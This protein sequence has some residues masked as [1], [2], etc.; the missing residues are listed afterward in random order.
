MFYKTAAAPRRWSDSRYVPLGCN[1][2]LPWAWTGIVL[3]VTMTVRRRAMRSE[4]RT[5]ERFLGVT[6]LRRQEDNVILIPNQR[7]CAAA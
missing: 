1:E 5:S 2:A 4:G 7:P 6:Q 3:V